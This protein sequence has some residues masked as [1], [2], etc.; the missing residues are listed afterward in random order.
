MITN[1]IT[2]LIIL[3]FS[4]FLII[5]KISYGYVDPGLIGAFWQILCTF[6][7]GFVIVWLTR[8]LAFIK[9]I[10][11]KQSVDTVEQSPS[12]D[13]PGVDLKEEND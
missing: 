4:L 2:K 12:N 9:R 6:I 3:S 10:F 1:K 8:P 11:K 13:N 7:F 5:P